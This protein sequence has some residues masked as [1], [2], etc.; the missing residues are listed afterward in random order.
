VKRF[1]VP[2]YW[3]DDVGPND[4][5]FEKAQLKPFEDPSYHDAARTLH[6]WQSK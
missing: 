4:P 6:Y 3:Y 2:I 1:G 5:D